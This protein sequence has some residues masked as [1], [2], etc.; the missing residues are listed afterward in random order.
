MGCMSIVSEIELNHPNSPP[1]NVISPLRD[2]TLL[3]SAEFFAI[4]FGLLSQIILTRGLKTAE[5]GMWILLFDLGL[6]IF[7]LADT[8][9]FQL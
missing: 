3:V 7:M 1:N 8:E 9:T 5:F 4:S 6:T 2:S